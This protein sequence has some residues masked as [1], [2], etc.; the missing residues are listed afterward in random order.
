MSHLQM[1][2]KMAKREALSC[3]CFTFFFYI[4]SHG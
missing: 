3:V 1:M 4:E 2:E